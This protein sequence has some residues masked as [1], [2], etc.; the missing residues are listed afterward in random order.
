MTDE[1]SHDSSKLT[2]VAVRTA[3]VLFLSTLAVLLGIAATLEPSSSGLGTHHQLGLPPCSVR[4]L[5]GIRCPVCGMTTAWAHFADGN[6]LASAR[7]NVGGL[8]LA[9]YLLCCVVPVARMTMRGALPSPAFFRNAALTLTGIVL[10]T[11]VDWAV[12]LATS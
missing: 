7:A 5:W 9:I 10:V 4:V 2:V 12:R 1:L 8:F 11:F 6:V 3:G